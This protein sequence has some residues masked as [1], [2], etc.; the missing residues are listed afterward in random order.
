[1]SKW[2]WFLIAVTVV[3]D[4]IVITLVLRHRMRNAGVDF[5]RLAKLTKLIHEAT[6]EHMR[7]N[8]SGNLEQLP[9]ALESLMPVVS[10]VIQ[11]GGHTL[12]DDTLRLL[13][14]TS[15]TQHR[16]APRADV[17]RA[18]EQVPRKSP[19]DRAA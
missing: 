8:Y 15:V 17:Q 14:I 13:V 1:L 5:A 6:G 7:A 16:F 3:I 2:F 18:M 9:S 19:L 12:D 11:H 4:A 10:S